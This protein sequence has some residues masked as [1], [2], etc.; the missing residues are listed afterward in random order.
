MPD[1]IYAGDLQFRSPKPDDFSDGFL[2]LYKGSSFSKLRSE[3]SID[4]KKLMPDKIYA[5]D[6][7]FRSPKPDNFSDGFL[8]SYKVS[9]LFKLRYETSINLK[10]L[11]ERIVT[12]SPKLMKNYCYGHNLTSFQF[13]RLNLSAREA[14]EEEKKKV[15]I[16]FENER[17]WFNRSI[18]DDYE[19]NKT[20]E[21]IINQKPVILCNVNKILN[22][23]SNSD[24]KVLEKKHNDFMSQFQKFQITNPKS[25]EK[26]KHVEEKENQKPVTPKT[27]QKIE[28]KF[29]KVDFEDKS[30]NDPATKN[31]VALE[32]QLDDELGLVKNSFCKLMNVAKD[33][34]DPEIVAKSEE[35]IR[36]FEKISQEKA[37]PKLKLLA[38][39]NPHNFDKEVKA[40]TDEHHNNISTMR[41]HLQELDSNVATIV[42]AERK[43][44]EEAERKCRRKQRSEL[45]SQYKVKFTNWDKLLKKCL[46]DSKK[47]DNR[48]EEYIQEIGKLGIER[49]ELE[50][51]ENMDE[52][53]FKS[54]ANQLAAMEAKYLVWYREV[55]AKLAD[56]CKK[57]Q[58][59]AA[60][61]TE[62][63]AQAKKKAE[64]QA[65]ARKVS[66]DAK[67]ASEA[68]RGEEKIENVDASRLGA[69]GSALRRYAKLMESLAKHR[70]ECE[71]V[72]NS[73]AALKR[74]KFDLQKAINF[75]I[76]ALLDDESNPDSKKQFTERMINIQRLLSGQTRPVTSTL[77]VNPTKHPKAIEFLLEYLAKK[78]VEK[79]EETVASRPES[80]FQYCEL[81]AAIIK[82]NEP[83]SDFLFA[84][85]YEKCPFTV[86][87]YKPRFE[88]QKIEDFFRS[89]GYKVNEDG[90]VEDDEY[91]YKRVSGIVHFYFTLLVT[92]D[93]ANGQGVQIA[94]NWFADVLNMKPRANITAHMCTIF[95]KCCGNKMQKIYGQ[96][97]NKLMRVFLTDFLPK[98]KAVPNQS[99][100]FLGRLDLILKEFNTY[101]HF[102]EWKK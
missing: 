49:L 34:V 98:I 5:G 99:G 2:N 20:L 66:E 62:A 3:T 73:D 86:P 60:R 51:Y 48:G 55:E 93:Y 74:Y 27:S 79:S 36:K 54:F 56:I 75:P 33:L 70:A 50:N 82:Q 14:E 1:K 15:K 31:L 41:Q 68:K 9:S 7:Q 32:K 90:T 45:L 72:F 21:S 38:K 19:A 69:T 101:S 28:E 6:L 37:I 64:A 4:L 16:S 23:V 29:I 87:Y 10:K 81:A 12:V 84:Y 80:V 91:F 42:A 44:K 40:F 95:F 78:L 61:A 85:I 24:Q 92:F 57:E 102:P 59:A 11:D 43:K 65:Q 77:T 96:Q 53:A 35:L 18:K 30:K 8:N 39:V 83:F 52:E 47:I 17:P 89:L 100:A 97:F 88:G 63:Q 67:K 25:P 58:D 13:E 26:K 46:P 22:L 76:N 71:A 94:W